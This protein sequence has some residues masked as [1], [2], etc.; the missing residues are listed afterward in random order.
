[1]VPLDGDIT[2]PP[3]D[4]P[5]DAKPPVDA[6]LVDARPPVDAKPID[7]PPASMPDAYQCQVMTRQLLVNPV[8][9]VDANGT[10]WTQQNIDNAYPIITSNGQL[11]AQS[12]PYRA[13]LGGFDGGDKGVASVTDQ[14]YQ[15]VAIP[16]N[17]TM[18]RLT[19]YYVI[20]STET[21]TTTVYDRGEIGLVQTNGT[22]IEVAK[23]F[24]NLT[25]TGATWTALDKTFTTNVSGQTV[26]LRMT[27]T[28]DVSNHSNFFFDSLALTA[29]YCQ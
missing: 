25:T 1:V 11:A 19:G 26:R 15:D 7:A 18:L 21:T 4:G 9:D 3:A 6:K 29:T 24:T 12:A 8:F 13:W 17:T 5:V 28:N 2:V 20:G 16:A 10:G 14:L 22:P 27:S 23:S